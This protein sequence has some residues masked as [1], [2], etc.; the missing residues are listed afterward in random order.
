MGGRA[1]VGWSVR[2][3]AHARSEPGKEFVARKRKACAEGSCGV[4]MLGRERVGAAIATVVCGMERGARAM[5]GGDMSGGLAST[6]YGKGES[7]CL[8]WLFYEKALDA[9]GKMQNEGYKV[10]EVTIVR[11]L[12]S[13]ARSSLL[14]VG[15]DVH[16]MIYAKEIK[17]NK[18]VMNALVDMYAKCGDL[19]DERLIFE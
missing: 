8:V 3:G 1:L 12:S 6:S 5:V 13:C 19:S 11:V 7:A 17:L 2:E 4:L 15:K 9:F 14:H 18:F 16:K 10:D